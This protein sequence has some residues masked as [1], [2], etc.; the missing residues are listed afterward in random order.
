MERWLL[1]VISYVNQH[2][3][4][5]RVCLRDFNIVATNKN[6]ASQ[7]AIL[8]AKNSAKLFEYD[9]GISRSKKISC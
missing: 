2:V 5:A 8:R 3:D 4:S 7:E 1:E 6:E 9:F